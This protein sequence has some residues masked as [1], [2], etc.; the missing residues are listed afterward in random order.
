MKPLEYL[1]DSLNAFEMQIFK[2]WDLEMVLSYRVALEGLHDLNS[3]TRQAIWQA[4][5]A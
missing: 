1:L 4:S 2:A 5:L 3:E